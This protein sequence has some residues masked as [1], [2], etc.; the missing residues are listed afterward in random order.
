MKLSRLIKVAR[1]IEPPD[2]VLKGGQ[3]V[4][5]LP[6][7]DNYNALIQQM[8]FDSP[9]PFAASFRSDQQATYQALCT[10]K[11]REDI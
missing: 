4:L 3:I 10:I 11:I 9:K 5:T 7:L 8:E 2:L 1:G 6:N